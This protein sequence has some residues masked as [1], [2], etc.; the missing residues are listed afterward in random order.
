MNFEF[1]VFDLA[2]KTYCNSTDNSKIESLLQN[3]IKSISDDDDND[4]GK[5]SDVLNQPSNYAKLTQIFG[6]MFKMA[7]SVKF[8]EWIC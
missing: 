2:V 8:R 6:E 7:Y 4:V 1:C 5:F 3:L